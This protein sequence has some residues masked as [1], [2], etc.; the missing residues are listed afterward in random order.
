MKAISLLFFFAACA[1]HKPKYDPIRTP[2]DDKNEEF[3][4]CFLESESYKGRDTN[5]MGVIKV[6]F[7]IDKVGKASQLKIVES[8]FKDPSFHACIFDQLRMIKFEPAKDGQ[9]IIHVQPIN[10]YPTYK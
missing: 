8:A 4:S 2:M 5:E 9:D 3:R 10:F 7:T 1:S 6:S